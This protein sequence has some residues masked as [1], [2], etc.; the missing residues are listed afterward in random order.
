MGSAHFKLNLSDAKP[1]LWNALIIGVGTTATYVLQ[2]AN[3]L[4]GLNPVVAA[5]IV[6]YVLK[7]INKFVS[8]N[9]KPI[10]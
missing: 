3:L 10:S 4:M 8:D 6:S 2:N 9:T 7:L 5:G 1:L